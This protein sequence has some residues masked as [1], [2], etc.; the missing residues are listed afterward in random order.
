MKRPNPR[1]VPPLP[2]LRHA[3]FLDFDG[4]L[5]APAEHPDPVI[6]PT[7]L[8][9]MLSGLE[10]R[11]GGA[12]AIVTGRRLE[13]LDQ[14]IAPLRLRAAGLHG[15]QMR[16][17]AGATA[18]EAR[19][20]TAVFERLQEQFSRD[21]AISIENK[22]AALAVH[23]REVPQR[24][25][26]IRATLN[27]LIAEHRLDVIAGKGVFELVGRGHGKDTAVRKLMATEPFRNRLPVFIGDDLSDEAGIREVQALGGF[28]IKV[29]P[30]DTVAEWRLASPDAVIAWLRDTLWS[31]PDV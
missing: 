8:V 2:T 18:S 13:S 5:V 25:A 12:L 15:A 27:L 16:L 30:G 20:L 14:K 1:L 7:L 28:G 3:L 26:E 29:G 22:G 21:P 17:D 11:F 6:V 31:L 24:A 9:G 19:P 23:W 10:R 4:T